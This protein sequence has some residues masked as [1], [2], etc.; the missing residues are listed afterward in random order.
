MDSGAPPPVQRTV[1]LTMPPGS[2]TWPLSASINHRVHTSLLVKVQK[3]SLCMLHLRGCM[4]PAYFARL[5]VSKRN[6]HMLS[7]QLIC[8]PLDALLLRTWVLVLSCCSAARS[9]ATAVEVSTMRL[10]SLPRHMRPPLGLPPPP[11]MVPDSLIMSPCMQQFTRDEHRAVF[12]QMEGIARRLSHSSHILKL[13]MHKAC[14][15]Q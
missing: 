13:D 14:E 3:Q 2:S 4:A 6:Y 7:P 11:L 8:L 10:A 5:S 1:P 15:H 12:A 9:S